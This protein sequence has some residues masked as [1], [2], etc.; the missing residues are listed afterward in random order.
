MHVVPSTTAPLCV[1]PL[2][3]DIREH[4][5]TKQAHHHVAEHGGVASPVSRLF[6]LEV[7]VGRDD[8]VE[9]APADDDANDDAALV[10]AFDVV[11]GPGEGVGDG[12]WKEESVYAT[13]RTGLHEV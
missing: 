12:G 8:T 7:D 13:T 5:T 9:V 11:A 4:S 6:L 1:L 2:Q 3:H 10:D